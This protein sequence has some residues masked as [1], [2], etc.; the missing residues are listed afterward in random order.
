MLGVFWI[1]SD[2]NMQC[3]YC[4]EGNDKKKEYMSSNT[5]DKAITFLVENMAKKS[6]KSLKI[7][8]HGGEPFLAFDLMKYLVKTAKKSCEQENIEL[9][10]GCT[11]NATLLSDEK[12]HF[13]CKEIQNLTISM[14]G[15][16]ETQNFSR[17]FKNGSPSYE[18]VDA[19]MRKIIKERPEVRVRLTF[20]HETVGKLYD[21]VK[22]LSDLGVKYIVPA[23]DFFD[24]S[25]GKKELELLKE[26]LLKIDKYI[27]KLHKDVFVGMLDRTLIKKL[28]RCSGGIDS[29]H[30]DQNG[31]IYPCT[32]AVGDERFIIGTL[33]DGINQEKRDYLLSF[34]DK[35]N[36]ECLGCDYYAYCEQTRCKIINKIIMDDFCQASPLDCAE[37]NILYDIMFRHLAV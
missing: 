25:F 7:E 14:D 1:T 30:F 32:L 17:P 35:D 6:D 20:T 15:N 34:S 19:T 8:I 31:V 2:C 12:F 22:Y 10:I 26:E 29:Y 28:G 18:I 9:T 3:I 21:N 27:L 13:A 16:I 37:N 11:T 23:R 4:Y 24:N 36:Y 33:D 5:V